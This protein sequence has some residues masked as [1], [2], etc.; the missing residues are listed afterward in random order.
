MDHTNVHLLYLPSIRK[1]SLPYRHWLTPD[2][3]QSFSLARPFK[4]YIF[5]KKSLKNKKE[6]RYDST[7]RSYFF[8]APQVTSDS[9]LYIIS[10]FSWPGPYLLLLLTVCTG[11]CGFELGQYLPSVMDSEDCPRANVH[12]ITSFY[13]WKTVSAIQQ[14]CTRNNARTDDSEVMS[15]LRSNYSSSWYHH[16][17]MSPTITTGSCPSVIRGRNS[18]STRFFPLLPY[19]S[20]LTKLSPV[21][22]S[23][24]SSRK[25]HP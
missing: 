4:I 12:G 21:R 8:L 11:A 15:N 19:F 10:L 9:T 20:F 23:I 22:D 13:M 18:V 1:G 7:C 24:Q 17:K 6:N 25:N 14:V 16:L 2:D 3:R 5:R